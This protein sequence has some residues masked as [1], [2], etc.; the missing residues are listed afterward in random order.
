MMKYMLKAIDNE[1][2]KGLAKEGG[3]SLKMLPTYVYKKEPTGNEDGIAVAL[4]LG[5][6]NFIVHKLVVRKG[7]IEEVKE[8]KFILPL[9]I[10]HSDVDY[11]FGYCAGI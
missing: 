6:T 1:M 4:D 10:K 9:G 2:T 8:H 3:S 11:L 7:K 5:G